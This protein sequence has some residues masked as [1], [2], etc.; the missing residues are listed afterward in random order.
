MNDTNLK[1]LP[2]YED[3]IV[4]VNKMIVMSPKTCRQSIG[5]ELRKS[6]YNTLYQIYRLIYVDKSKKLSVCNELDSLFSYQR[7]VIRCMYEL[8]YIDAKKK[9]NSIKMLGE[10]GKMLGGYVKSLGVSYAKNV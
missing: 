1:L 5:D 7:A 10:L 3:Y 8:G 6:M 2:K 4:Y 9:I